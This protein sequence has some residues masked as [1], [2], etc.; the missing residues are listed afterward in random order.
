MLFAFKKKEK[1]KEKYQ[2]QYKVYFFLHCIEVAL[3][4]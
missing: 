2:P 1:R 3:W 4:E